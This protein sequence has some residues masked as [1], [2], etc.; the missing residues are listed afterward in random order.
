MTKHFIFTDKLTTD[1]IASNC[2]FF[3]VE[4]YANLASVFYLYKE[5]DL[6]GNHMEDLKLISE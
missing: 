6:S 5:K 3:I 1:K 2:S 4:N